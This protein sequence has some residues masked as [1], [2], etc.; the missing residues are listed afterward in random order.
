MRR[1]HFSLG[2][3]TVI[4][5]LITG[6]LMRHHAPPLITMTDSVR[7]MYRSRHIYILAAGLVHLVL[8]IYWQA[9]EGWRQLV[10]SAGSVLLVAAVP[11]LI[12]AFFVESS[13]D[14]RDATLWSHFGLYA[15]FGGAML[16]GICGL[17]R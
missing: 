4:A 13:V 3:L 15:L 5:F 7:L 8:G 16:H 17:K 1:L 14:L 6:Q 10:Q 12:A 9:L 11:L 2:W